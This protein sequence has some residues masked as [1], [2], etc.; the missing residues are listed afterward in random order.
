MTND[1]GP[2]AESFAL[3]TT[4]SWA[5]AVAEGQ[6][7]VR[8]GLPVAE[9]AAWAGTAMCYVELETAFVAVSTIAPR[10]DYSS[11]NSLSARPRM[12]GPRLCVNDSLQI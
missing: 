12:R 6:R 3:R 7:N 5:M 9:W 11:I 2:M 8:G 10:L 1:I 4:I